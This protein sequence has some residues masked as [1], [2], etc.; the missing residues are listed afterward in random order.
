M[1]ILIK[2]VYNIKG[3]GGIS[4][5]T[6][7]EQKELLGRET[8]EEGTND[9]AEESTGLQSPGKSRG[10]LELLVVENTPEGS[11]EHDTTRESITSE[12][13]ERGSAYLVA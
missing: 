1:N 11:H 5:L 7:K 2:I 12:W 3:S 13:M 6:I 10:V 9:V 8:N 4:Q